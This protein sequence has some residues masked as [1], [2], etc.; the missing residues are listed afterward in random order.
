M[1]REVKSEEESEDWPYVHRI[2][3]YQ[4][5]NFTSNCFVINMDKYLL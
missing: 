4:S 2:Y 1:K 5:N 3:K